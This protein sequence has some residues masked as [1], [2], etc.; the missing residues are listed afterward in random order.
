MKVLVTNEPRRIVPYL[1]GVIMG[2]LKETALLVRRGLSLGVVL[3]L[4]LSTLST[5]NRGADYLEASVKNSTKL[6]HVAPRSLTVPKRVTGSWSAYAFR[7]AV[8]AEAGLDA[9]K[10]LRESS[11]FLSTLRDFTRSLMRLG[12]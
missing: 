7:P 9:V 8:R 5:L 6:S 2:M 10:T 4:A 12:R 11:Y 3:F 1:K